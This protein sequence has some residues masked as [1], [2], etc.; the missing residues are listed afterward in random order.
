MSEKRAQ[1]IAISP[2]LIHYGSYKEERL[3]LDLRWFSLIE[4]LGYAPLVLPFSRKWKKLFDSVEVIGLILSGGNNLACTES[5]ELSVKRD[6]FET[7]FLQYAI[8][9]YVPILGICRG[10]QFINHYFGGSLKKVLG[11]V[12]RHHHVQIQPDSILFNTLGSVAYL[13]SFHHYG[14][15]QLP[16][17]LLPLA[18]ASDDLSIEAFLHHQSP[19]LGLLW[20]PERFKEG[21]INYQKHIELLNSFFSNNLPP[22]NL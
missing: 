18:W 10:M 20:H 16:K 8:E 12:N 1:F 21:S 13:N 19:I 5:N 9:K 2:S 17:E 7:Y 11:H 14:I 3:T 6:E 22:V 15:S 4:A